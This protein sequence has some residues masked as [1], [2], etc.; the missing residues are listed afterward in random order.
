MYKLYVLNEKTNE[1][2]V[3]KFETIELALLYRDYHL[4]FGTWSNVSKWKSKDDMTK[5]DEPFIVDSKYIEKD[6]IPIQFFK[7]ASGFRIKVQKED[8]NSL[9]EM[10]AIFRKKR[11]L[12]LEKTDWTQLADV[13][14]DTEER[15]EFRLYRNYLREL[16]KLYNDSSI[17]YAKVY[18]FEDWKKGNR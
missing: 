16:P 12:M 2:K 13:D 8:K 14:L 17:S 5:E 7:I 10:W 11:Q 1:E 4:A 15:K 6:G 9:E 18:S 3:L